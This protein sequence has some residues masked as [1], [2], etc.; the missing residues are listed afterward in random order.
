MWIPCRIGYHPL[1][2]FRVT[3]LQDLATAVR[4]A[5]EEIGLSLDDQRSFEFVM[6]C[7]YVLALQMC[8]AIRVHREAAP[9]IEWRSEYELVRVEAYGTDSIRVRF[10]NSRGPITDS[11]LGAVLPTPEL[12][13]GA[14]RA[15][16]ASVQLHPPV[17]GE[18]AGGNV[19][20]GCIV[21]VVTR[22]GGCCSQQP[23]SNMKISFYSTISQELLTEEFYP[24]HGVGARAM[25]PFARGA[26]GLF[27]VRY[28]VRLPVCP[29][30]FL[31]V[32]SKSDC[33]SAVCP[34]VCAV[35]V[36][37]CTMQL[38]AQP[39]ERFYGLGQ[40]SH[41]MLN[42]RGAVIDLD[43]F[44]TEVNVPL[45]F[46]SRGYAVLWNVPSRGRVELAANRTRFVAEATRQVFWRQPESAKSPK[47]QALW[48]PV[49]LGPSLGR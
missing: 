22:D 12:P 8:S 20:N 42:Q 10:T 11:A 34:S 24:H 21:A 7:R 9:G 6:W 33:L 36:H 16:G 27:S 44:N 14:I 23:G 26:G 48:R 49:S 41:G 30:V 31:P 32:C 38:A 46:S 2:A 25:M 29:S 19:S 45:L 39:D 37:A 1:H 15:S 5:R 35:S 13:F 28:S 18:P 3:A 47:L 17:H 43:Q 40:H 4:E